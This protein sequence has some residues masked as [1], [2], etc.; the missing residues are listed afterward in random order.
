MRE[1]TMSDEMTSDRD[2][3]SEDEVSWEKGRKKKYRLHIRIDLKRNS[4]Y[5]VYVLWFWNTLAVIYKSDI[6]VCMYN[7]INVERTA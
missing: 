6:M 4:C 7:Y 5:I 1:M 3:W 2:E